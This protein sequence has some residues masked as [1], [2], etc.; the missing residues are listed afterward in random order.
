[1][2]ESESE[3]ERAWAAQIARARVDV[4]PPTNVEAVLRAVRTA[5][6]APRSGWLIELASVFAGA[7]AVPACLAAT[8]LLGG[9]AS[10]EA[11]GLWQ[12]LPWAEM[13]VET[14]GG[15]P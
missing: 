12:A 4:A 13:I 5:A 6:V 2:K 8:L 7:R 1:M 15:M 14:T 10:W 9:L 3:N 11:W